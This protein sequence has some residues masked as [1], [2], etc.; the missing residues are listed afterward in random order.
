M[1]FVNIKNAVLSLVACVAAAVV[2]SGCSVADAVRS[3]PETVPS[4]PQQEAVPNVPSVPEGYDEFASWNSGETLPEMVIFGEMVGLE[5]TLPKADFI[6]EGYVGVAPLEALCV[7]TFHGTLEDAQQTGRLSTS[8]LSRYNFEFEV[9]MPNATI[10]EI[11]LLVDEMRAL[12]A[13]STS[14]S[15]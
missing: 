6:E 2:L 12:C 5:V 3:N 15:A 14:M 9:I 1:H 8:V 11:K 10:A 7:V 4:A 13:E